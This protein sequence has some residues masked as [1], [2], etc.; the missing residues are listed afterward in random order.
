[1]NVR[2]SSFHREKCGRTVFLKKL[3]NQGSSGFYAAF[4]RNLFETVFILT[5]Y[6]F[7]KTTENRH[8]QELQ[9]IVAP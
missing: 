2:P 8:D 3:Y 7:Q 9:E 6:F 5:T 1:M 4:Y